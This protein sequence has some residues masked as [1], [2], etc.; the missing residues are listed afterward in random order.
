VDGFARA[1]PVRWR[2]QVEQARPVQARLGGA[3]QADKKDDQHPRDK[4]DDASDKAGYLRELTG[5][6]Q[7][8]SSLGSPLQE[9]TS[10]RILL[11]IGTNLPEGLRQ[12]LRQLRRLARQPTPEQPAQPARQDEQREDHQRQSDTVPQPELPA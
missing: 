3:K 7:R 1:R 11:E 2:N 8:T 10:P 4:I 12:L 9:R 6:R 5:V